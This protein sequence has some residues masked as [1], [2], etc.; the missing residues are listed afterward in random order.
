M[1]DRRPLTTPGLIDEIPSGDRLEVEGIVRT[2]AGDLTFSDPNAGTKTLAQ[3][4]VGGIGGSTG[5]VDN[6]LLR[7]NG[8]AGDTVQAGSPATLSDTGLI[9]G[10]IGLGLTPQGA[11]PGGAATG[12]VSSADSRLYLGADKI[13]NFADFAA[14]VST[15][16][17]VGGA[18]SVNGGD[19][20][21]FD[22]S[23]GF[24]FFVDNSG[25]LPVVNR[26]EWS[27]ITAITLTFLATDF[28]TFIALS[29]ASPT[30]VTVI[31]S[32]VPFTPQQAKD[33]I[34]LGR[35]VHPNGVSISS[36]VTFTTAAYDIDGEV[37][38]FFSIFG[39][40]NVAGNQFSWV[41]AGA[42]LQMSK[43]SGNTW[44]Y[45]ANYV[46]SR[47]LRSYSTDAT[48]A[49]CTWGYIYQ[50]PGDPSGFAIAVP[51]TLID[52]ANYDD[53]SG[54]LAAV[55]V[56]KWSVQRV[57]H[58]PSS[59]TLRVHYGQHTYNS[60]DEAI[61]GITSD[62]VA[63]DPFL[64]QFS[65]CTYIVVKQGA[66]A[67]N[68]ANVIFRT[69]G[70]FGSQFGGGGAGEANTSSNAGATGT[71]IALAKVGVDLPFAKINGL[72]GISEALVSNVL[73]L[74]GV[75][76][77]PRDGTRAMTAALN[78][79]GFGLVSLGYIAISPTAI[80][81][82]QNNYSPTSWSGADIVRLTFTGSQTIT[83]FDSVATAV[84]KIIVNTDTVDSLTIANES[85]SSTAANRVI[86][87]NGA[88]LVV[89]PGGTVTIVYDTTSTRWRPIAI[90][91]VAAASV[92]VLVHA[93]RRSAQISNITTTFTFPAYDTTLATLNT[94]YFTFSGGTWT[95]VQALKL[96]VTSEISGQGSGAVSARPA[97]DHVW[98]LNGST[99][100]T[101]IQRQETECYS[102]TNN[103]FGLVCTGFYDF[104]AGNQ[105]RC[106]MGCLAGDMD[107][108][109]DEN[110]I[111]L[112]VV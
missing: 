90:N 41:G 12:W 91:N 31:Q 85:G 98:S 84:R 7:A 30:S 43:T 69:A 110:T 23:A 76:L 81:A 28:T 39:P 49:A 4:S 105:Y 103:H 37:A 56:N 60:S 46:S 45:G 57:F 40:I 75:A 20:A 92:P 78:M 22:I 29:Y 54:T 66:T 109:A 63:I 13:A 77:L 108:F 80:A 3:L 68:S 18:M 48:I 16:V 8:V 58:E 67:A 50:D 5:A 15:G 36:I 6:A 79:G 47:E 14:F 2:V 19:P 33:Y 107:V 62:Q 106:Y 1:A 71:G 32:D 96:M 95:C 17:Y 83:G 55:P 38:Q 11:N 97:I 94:S 93:M 34:V 52:S 35:V 44:S 70:K 82:Q 65:L 27:A 64:A 72:N 102:T 61:V 100:T 25:S 51:I 53:G 89:P 9:D 26:C 112:F 24:G 73:E 21:K 74:D 10:V 87:P 101:L 86:C 111:R 59:Q 99:W 42:D 88:N 104:A